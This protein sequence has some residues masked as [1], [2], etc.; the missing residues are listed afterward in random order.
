[1]IND[2]QYNTGASRPGKKNCIQEDT[3]EKRKA[4]CEL[5]SKDTRTEREREG[6]NKSTNDRFES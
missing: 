6:K 1:M 5:P 2:S 3:V 4:M